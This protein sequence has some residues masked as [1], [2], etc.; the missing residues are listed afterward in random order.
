MGER[1][2]GT[3]TVNVQLL[4]YVTRRLIGGYKGEFSKR[5]AEELGVR[6]TAKNSSVA[7]IGIKGEEAR[8]KAAESV[9]QKLD[10]KAGVIASNNGLNITSDV[11]KEHWDHLRVDMASFLAQASDGLARGISVTPDFMSSAA[12]VAM[13]ALT[14]PTNDNSAGKPAPAE[15]LRST[16][17]ASPVFGEAAA[18]TT[19]P[20]TK[21]KKRIAFKSDEEFAPRNISQA[22][23][24]T[25]ALDTMP[26]EQDG[27]RAQFVNSYIYAGGPAGGGKTYAALQA[28]VDAYRTGLVDEIIIIRPPTT[29]GKDPGAM[30]GDKNKKSEPYLAGGIASN[31]EKITGLTMKEL[32]DKKIVRAIL[33]DWERGETYGT[34]KSPVFVVIDEPQNLTMQQAELLVTRLGEGSIMLWCGDIGGKQ[35]D[36][37]NQV[38]GLAHLIATQG[39]GKMSNAILSRATAFIQFTEEDSSARNKILPHVLKAL[40]TP[41]DDYASLMGDFQLAGQNPKLAASIEAIRLYAVDILEKTATMTKR[42]YEKQ[43]KKDYPRLYVAGPS[44]VTPITAAGR[45]TL[46]S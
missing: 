18:K 33:P 31:L 1:F 10:Q 6:I 2:N 3:R 8:I 46:S 45:H 12:D 25:A 13:P 38:P 36:L 19:A 30:P 16:A 5:I 29:A 14:G 27:G 21:I 28:A 42:H 24:Y 4:S 40:S 32:Q 11:H 35:N 20:A 17:A 43:I 15:S 23:T 7:L 34:D 26:A 39:A 22:L 44:N 37:K 9:I 41:P